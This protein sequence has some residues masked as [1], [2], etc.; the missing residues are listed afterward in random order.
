M[1]EGTEGGTHV[2]PVNL[3]WAPPGPMISFAISFILM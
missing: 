1:K 2:L 3:D